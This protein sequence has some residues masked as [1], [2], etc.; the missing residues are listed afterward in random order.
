M[1]WIYKVTNDK[2]GKM[3][4]GKTEYADPQKRWKAH[5]K[6]YNSE[7][8]NVPFYCAIRKYGKEHF[9]FEVIEKTDT[10]EESCEREIYWID[11]LRTYVNFDD[12]NGY[13]ATLGGD[14]AS[15]YN[16]NE[17][18][19]IDYYLN[20]YNVNDTAKHYN[21][22]KNTITNILKKHNITYVQGKDVNKLKA[23]LEYGGVY[24]VD[25]KTK[26][27]ID[28]YLTTSDAAKYLNTNNFSSIARACR[29]EKKIEPHL[30]VGY[31]WYYGKDIPEAIEKGKIRTIEDLGNEYYE[32]YIK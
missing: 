27:I 26:L 14:G 4:I 28:S 9:H 15:K 7:S 17:E 6:A 32:K 3:Y 24:K 12:C 30:S 18:E 21:V 19:I 1:G 5:L 22:G 20:N 11:K 16:L 29:G 25:P 2:N 10:P 31:L 8:H 13:N 23:Y